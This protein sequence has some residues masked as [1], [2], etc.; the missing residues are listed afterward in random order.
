MPADV[1]D[2]CLIGHI[3]QNWSKAARERMKTLTAK[4]A[5]YGFGRLIDLARAEPVVVAKHSRPAVVVIGIG[6]F[7]R[8]TA[9]DT[10]LPAPTPARNQGSKD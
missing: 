2:S 3:G 7:E 4:D 1:R 6:E 5:N 8:L 9:L 10:P